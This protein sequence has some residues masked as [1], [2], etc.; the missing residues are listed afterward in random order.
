MARQ[1]T[2]ANRALRVGDQVVERLKIAAGQAAAS[3]CDPRPIA[4][5]Q[6]MQHDAHDVARHD[7]IG[8]ELAAGDRD[9]PA[10]ARHDRVFARHRARCVGGGR[11]AADEFRPT[12]SRRRRRRSFAVRK[13]RVR[14]VEQIADVLVRRAGV[15]GRRGRIRVGRSDDR[16]LPAPAARRTR[17]RRSAKAASARPCCR[18]ARAEPRCARLCSR[19]RGRRGIRRGRRIEPSQRVAPRSRRV[20][21]DRRAHIRRSP[22]SSHPEPLRQRSCRRSTSNA[23]TGA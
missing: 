6:S 16:V 8:R 21:D 17:G 18:R 9:E 20:D 11:Q 4:A 13:E 5:S 1:R 15:V 12:R 23:V 2:V 7:A 3:P 19:A 14:R 10:R 22:D